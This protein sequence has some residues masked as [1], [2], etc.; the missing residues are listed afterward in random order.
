[1]IYFTSDL[2]YNHIRA[3]ELMPLRPW[4]TLEDMNEGLIENH[5]NVVKPTDTVIILGDFIMGLK[6]ETVPKIVP[7]L[8][9][10][11]H[12]IVGNHDAGWGD[13]SSPKIQ[14]Y[15]DNGVKSVWHGLVRFDALLRGINHMIPYTCPTLNLCHLPYK[16][17]ADHTDL[18]RYANIK[19]ESS[20]IM[21]LHGHTHSSSRK[22]SSNMIHI[23]VDSWD[24]FPVSY[25]QIV[26]ML[27]S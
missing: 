25:N 7:R 10:E 21:L 12:L 26:E 27:G 6:S 14:V 24:W 19:P 2:H 13:P 23:G 22:T 8:N 9:G 16:G 17:V 5:N 4:A 20:P 15:L 18:D 3:L 1:M 11:L